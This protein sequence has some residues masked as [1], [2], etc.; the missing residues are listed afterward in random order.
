VTHLELPGVLSAA[1][2]AR[3]ADHIAALQQADGLFPWLAGDH[4]DPWNHVEAAM[5]MT[6]SGRREAARRAFAWS[7]ANQDADGT[8]PM[9]IVGTTVR[10]ASVDANQCAYLAVGIWQDWLVNRDRAF[11][12]EMWPVVRAAIAFVCDL[13]QPS[14]AVAWSRSADG[15]ISDYALRIGSG[16]MVLS[17]RCAMALAELVE[18][19][20]PD[21]ELT[22]AR[23]AH[24]V[25]AHPDAFQEQ[26]RF[27][28]EW[29]YPI[30]GGAVRGAAA[31]S[32]LA[33]RWDEFVVAGRGVRCV[34]DR[35]WVTAAETCELVLALDAVGDHAR[36]TQLL[37][38]VQFLR[39][40][41]GGYW[42][43]WVW[44]EDVFWPT[45]QSTWTGAAVILA[46]DALAAHSPA[47][48]LFRGT[49]L[50]RLLDVGGCDQHCYVPAGAGSD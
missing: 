42:T 7:A 29:Y 41:N 43:G 1:Q 39:A 11:I 46:A 24:V 38:D 5:A 10:E 16:C 48:A 36:A 32:L 13:Q 44:P 12:D 37:R 19:P 9:E 50:P 31:Q 25:A 35:P 40:D 34:A 18:D 6:V 21:W 14:G 22:A 27:S 26:S 47:H 15:V 4:A 45:E 23:L 2:V 28:M 17:L 20:Q 33:S 30:L 8:W 3:T 49:G